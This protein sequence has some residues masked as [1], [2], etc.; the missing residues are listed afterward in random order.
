MA[1]INPYLTFEGN[2]EEAFNFYRT[3]FGGE[4]TY[5]GRFHEMPDEF[6]IPE[7]QEDY[8]M[9]VSLPIGDETVLMGSDTSEAFGDPVKKGNNFSI[10]VNTDSREEADRFFNGLSENGGII[11]PMNETFWGSYFGMLTDKFGIQ[12][13]VSF[14]LDEEQ[15]A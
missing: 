10:S 2:C 13:M 6:D 9:H 11:M 8:V 15:R 14:E 5:L 12:W 4:F 1:T 3:V 7:G